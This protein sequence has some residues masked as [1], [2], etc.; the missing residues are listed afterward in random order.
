MST[1]YVSNLKVSCRVLAQHNLLG[2]GVRSSSSSC[3]WPRG[4]QH[5][6]K[7][8]YI[9]DALIEASISTRLVKGGG[10]DGED[11]AGPFLTLVSKL[12]LTMQLPLKK[13]QGVN[14]DTP[15]LKPFLKLVLTLHLKDSPSSSSM[16]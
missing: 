16:Q 14:I 9:P 10:G 7:C 3:S 15:M 5:A 6:T 13:F 11:V 12:V 4:R 2:K 8:M 1:T